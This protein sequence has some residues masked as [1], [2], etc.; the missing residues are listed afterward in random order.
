MRETFNPGIAEWTCGHRA[1]AVC[2]QCYE[3]LARKANLLAAEN[4]RLEAEI[5]RLRALAK[6]E[7][8]GSA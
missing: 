8:S 2:K 1:S 5:G 4:E 3:L 6:R 7:R